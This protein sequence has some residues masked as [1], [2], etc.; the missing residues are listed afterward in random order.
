MSVAQHTK[1]QMTTQ[2][3][4]IIQ[5]FSSRNRQADNPSQTA[6]SK[7]QFVQDFDQL[8]LVNKA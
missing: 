7:R 5:Q 3:N 4:D 1:R 2:L 8:L 6:A